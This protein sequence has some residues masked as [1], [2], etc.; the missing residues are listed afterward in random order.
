MASAFPEMK[1]THKPLAAPAVAAAQADGMFQMVSYTT[2][3]VSDAAVEMG[4]QYRTGGGRNYGRFSN[5]ASDR[6]LDNALSELNRDARTKL[7]DE[8]QQKWVAEWRPLIAL[9]ANGAKTMVQGSIGGYDRIAGTWL[10]DQGARKLGRLFMT[11]ESK[12]P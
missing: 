6:I 2:D 7:I 9:Y 8:Y 10:A 1:V 5:A 11:G 3:A 4:T 12:R